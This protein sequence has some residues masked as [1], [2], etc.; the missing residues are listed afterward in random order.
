VRERAE[1]GLARARRFTWDAS[2]AAHAAIWR[3]VLSGCR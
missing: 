2:A 3:E 1:R